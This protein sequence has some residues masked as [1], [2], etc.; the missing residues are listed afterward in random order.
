MT[1][2]KNY[3]TDLELVRQ[4]IKLLENYRFDNIALNSRHFDRL[5]LNIA[6]YNDLKQTDYEIVKFLFIEEN[7]WRKYD[8]EGEVDNLYFSA[9]LLTHFNSPELIWLFWEA[10]KIDFDSGIGFDEEHLISAGIKE[11]YQYLKSVDNPLKDELLQYIGETEEGCTYSQADVDEWKEN[12]KFYFKMYKFP[13]QDELHF[14]YSTNEKELFSAKLPG[15]INHRSVWTEEELGL[16]RIYAKYMNDRVLEIEALKLTIEK[17]DKDFLSDI[18]N[19]QLAE[20]YVECCE[21]DKALEL[22]ERLIKETDNGNVVRDCIEQLCMV[23]NKINDH[24]N[25]VAKKSLNII[26]TQREKYKSF[27]PMVDDLI[28]GV[29][30]MMKT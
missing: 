12:K 19:L 17:N 9:F 20:L 11:T 26:T 24:S 6:I 25:E 13:I 4:N 15:W 8:K 27:S 18:F 23:I 3:R 30:A 10:K 2:E 21:N 5:R 14:Y 28:K 29:T 7:K 22:L 16:Y 1:I